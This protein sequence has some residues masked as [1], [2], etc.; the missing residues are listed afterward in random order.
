MKQ[1]RRKNANSFVVK[2]LKEHTTPEVLELWK[3]ETNQNEWKTTLLPKKPIEDKEKYY[4]CYIL[5]GFDN[6]DKIRR[7]N[8]QLSMVEITRLIAKYWMIHKK[9]NDE[10]Y[11][12]YTLLFE[13]M[14]FSRKHKKEL[15]E[16][17]PEKT[18]AEIDSLLTKMHAK[19]T[20]D[21]R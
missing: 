3:S 1:N 16:R 17:Y 19:W 21:D 20:G 6:R 4:S 15:V 8:P 5:Y 2:F 12:H 9:A 11:K 7:S 14:A 18:E 10:T 13:R